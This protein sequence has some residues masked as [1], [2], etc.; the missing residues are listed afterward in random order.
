[1]LRPF[2]PV[3]GGALETTDRLAGKRERISR[4]M[5]SVSLSIGAMF[6]R[7]EERDLQQ[8]N[9]SAEKGEEKGCGDSRRTWHEP[10]RGLPPTDWT[11]QKKAAAAAR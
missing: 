6:L 8:R 10:K 2:K 1:M 3:F 5:S 7:G 4:R 9:G 11:W